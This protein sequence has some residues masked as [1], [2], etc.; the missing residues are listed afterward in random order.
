MG[1]LCICHINPAVCTLYHSMLRAVKVARTFFYGLFCYGLAE[2]CT[3]L[4]G[5]I[6]IMVQFS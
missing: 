5:D 2:N 4:R 3:L 6:L 1:T